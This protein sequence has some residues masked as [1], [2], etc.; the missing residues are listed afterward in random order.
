[1]ENKTTINGHIVSHDESVNAGIRYLLHLIEEK[2]SR[3]FFDQA[4][5]HGFAYFEDQMGYN[6]KL[7][8]HGS[9]YQ[10]IKA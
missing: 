7:I 6:Y 3:V 1:M 4:Y 9:E 8:H 2:E 5:S 10:L